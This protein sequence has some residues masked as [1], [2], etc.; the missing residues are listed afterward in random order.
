MSSELCEID[1]NMIYSIRNSALVTKR[2]LY[3]EYSKTN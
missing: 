1:K 3:T 2:D